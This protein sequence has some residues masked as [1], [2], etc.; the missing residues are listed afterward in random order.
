MG[1]QPLVEKGVVRVNQRQNRAIMPE[2]VVE[3]ENC[4]LLHIGPES[5][6]GR[7]GVGVFLIQRRET[8]DMQPL[9]AE[10]LDQPP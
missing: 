9:Q 3:K 10:L 7:K 1:R 5:G 8:G 6:K 4:L 2:E